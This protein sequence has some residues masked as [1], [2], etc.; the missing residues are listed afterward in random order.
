MKTNIIAVISLIVA[1]AVGSLVAYEVLG[2]MK[3]SVAVSPITVENTGTA[4]VSVP[5]SGIDSAPLHV[6]YNFSAST[7]LTVKVNGQ[8]VDNVSLTGSGA[9]DNDVKGYIVVG[10]NTL[11]VSVD[12]SERITSLSTTLDVNTQG[13]K[14][15]ESIA[16]K[17]QTAFNLMAILIIVMVAV[18][19]VMA[20]MGAFRGGAPTTTGL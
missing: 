4:S 17:G 10:T 3:E 18:L 19:I 7:L 5:N 12:N 8:V 2:S 13:E 6:D 9:I 20:V 1:I 15:E 16:G 11:Q 14:V